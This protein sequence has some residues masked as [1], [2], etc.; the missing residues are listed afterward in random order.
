[1][2]GG[3]NFLID[4]R[5]ITIDADI[6]QDWVARY[7]K[8][9]IATRAFDLRNGAKYMQCDPMP[10]PFGKILSSQGV[11][12]LIGMTFH[13]HSE[14]MSKL[15]NQARPDIYRKRRI[16][17][18]LQTALGKDKQVRKLVAKGIE[19][20]KENLKN[21]IR[22]HVDN[23]YGLDVKFI[24]HLDI[25]RQMYYTFGDFLIHIPDIMY[26]DSEVMIGKA[27]L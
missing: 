3:H 9:V 6:W 25:P 11:D 15:C 5:A 14:F 2:I 20:M 23:E 26:P 18:E 10:Q 19:Q 13:E 21:R 17:V 4:G 7:A 12:E 1:M 8:I 24:Q 16:R 27:A 22:V